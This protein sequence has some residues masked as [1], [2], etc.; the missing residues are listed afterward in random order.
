MRTALL[1]LLAACS[2]EPRSCEEA[3]CD[4]A[5]EWCRFLGSDT[6]APST[7][8]CELLPNDCPD[9]ATCDC[10]LEPDAFGTCEVV[11]GVVEVVIPGG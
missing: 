5:T 7:A 11:D 9:P 10:V 2:S 8:S 3:A 6:L 4:G 1:L